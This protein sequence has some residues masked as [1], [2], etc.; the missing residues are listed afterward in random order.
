[1]IFLAQFVILFGVVAIAPLFHSQPITGPLVNAALFLSVA[2]LGVQAAVLVELIPSVIALSTG[3]LPA[4][5]ASMVPFIMLGNILLILVFHWIKDLNVWG[6]I[7]LASMLKFLFLWGSSFIVV[8]LLLKKEVASN[9]V[10]ILSWPQL[11]TAL[12]G[13]LIAV[14]GLRGMRKLKSWIAI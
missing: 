7:L 1:M 13:G 11:W 2:L 12:V 9:V 5:L 10:A 6:G 14:L 4:V 3:L 8:D